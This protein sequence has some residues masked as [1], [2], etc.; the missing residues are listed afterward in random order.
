V[1]QTSLDDLLRHDGPP[2]ADV[3]EQLDFFL[4]GGGHCGGRETDTPQVRL[5]AE[6]EI[7]SVPV[8][9]LSGFDHGSDVQVI[10][11]PPGRAQRTLTM[12]R[13][14]DDLE[15]LHL[16]LAAGDPIGLYRVRA[17]QGKRVATTVLE[18]RRAATPRLWVH[19]RR[20]TAGD[21][22]DV[23]V[24][25]L[26][27]S[28]SLPLHLYATEHMTYRAT[29]SIATD[30]NGEGHVRIRTNAATIPDW[31]G[32]NTPLIYDPVT[33][34]PDPHAPAQSVFWLWPP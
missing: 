30:A 17:V 32:V 2:P 14:W 11:T 6:M 7:P 3:H 29:F 10:V 21:T 5:P 27:P 25:G 4:G 19:P 8:A 15:G 28:R 22:I 13:G 20:A 24:G 12:R 1:Q 31:Y 26:P 34:G 33:P 18:V 9:C 16:P 23:Y